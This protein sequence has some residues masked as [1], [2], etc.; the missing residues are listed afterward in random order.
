MLLGE[1][2]KPLKKTYYGTNFKQTTLEAKY[3]AAEAVNYSLGK[4]GPSTFY[5]KIGEVVF[6]KK[7][8][9]EDFKPIMTENIEFEAKELQDWGEDD[10]IMLK[11]IA[12]KINNDIVKTIR[13]KNL[14]FTY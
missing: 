13:A 5:V 11:K 9:V 1:L 6:N 4:E 7:G 2:K 3:V 8:E 10:S 14:I 12:K